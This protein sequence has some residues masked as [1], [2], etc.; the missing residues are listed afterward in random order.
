MSVRRGAV[1][2]MFY[3]SD[4]AELAGMI[5]GHLE[6]AT[7]LPVIDGQL[8]ALIVPHAGLVYSGQIAAHA[9]KL[10]EHSEINKVVICGPSHRFGFRGISVYGPGVTWKSPLGT[11]PCDDALCGRLLDHDAEIAVVKQF[12]HS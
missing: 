6:S 5:Q 1:A 9:Y 11:T 7:D 12:A 2:G 8:I 4:S 10:L 3:P